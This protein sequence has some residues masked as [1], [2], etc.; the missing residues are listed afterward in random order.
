MSV[1]KQN[2]EFAWPPSDAPA[3]LQFNPVAPQLGTDTA[4]C[5]IATQFSIFFDGTRNHAEE[6][7]PS[8]S[9]SN[10]ARLFETCLAED[11]GGQFRLYIP[12]VGTPFPPIGEPVPH[13]LGARD[14]AYGDR[15]LRYAYLYIANRIAELRGYPL[16]VEET[17]QALA[18][19]IEDET[20]VAVWTGKLSEIF[21]KP[22]PAAPQIVSITLDLFGFSR[23]ATAA[24]AFLNQLLEWTGTWASHMPPNLFGAPLRVRFMG[25]F[26]TVASVHIAD[27]MPLP[28]DGHLKWAEPR[29]MVIPA[30]VEQC[31]HMVAAH[32]ARNS[33]PL[34]TI[35]ASQQDAPRRLEIIYP[36]MHSDVGGGYGPRS[37]GKGTLASAQVRGSEAGMLSQIPLND[38]YDRA[39]AAGV[40]LMDR[41]KLVRHRTA[42]KFTVSPEL[43][44][45]FD[46]YQRTLHAFSSGAPLLTQIHQHYLHYLGWRKH[47]L[48]RG[49]FIAMPFM[50]RCRNGEPQDFVNLDQANVELQTYIVPFM[51]SSDRAVIQAGK[52]LVVHDYLL[53]QHDCMKLYDRYW[54]AL[55]APGEPLRAL[56]E[57]YAHDSRAAFVLTDPQCERDYQ[58]MHADL[59][60]LDA[61]YRES[62]RL[63]EAERVHK[64]QQYE[65]ALDSHDNE[66]FVPGGW[67]Q[68]KQPRPKPPLIRPLPE[69][70]LNEA[71]R[72]ALETYR[73]GRKPIFSDARP[74][75]S[76]DGKE[77][78]LDVIAKFSRRE[79]RWSYL[80]RRQVFRAVTGT[81]D[82]PRGEVRD[83]SKMSRLAFADGLS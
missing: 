61:Q 52:T 36:G 24:R 31:V 2:I 77:D 46:S 82:N 45:A 59:E 60:R 27:S 68:T 17:D 23:G 14:G 80:R 38:M 81:T 7:E 6:D 57:G 56:L 70:P 1:S 63:H 55:P 25:L 32:E 65:K 47:V 43:Q 50:Q 3:T 22:K 21:A 19:A 72:K 42:S 11:Q 83:N 30:F 78:A 48:Q 5:Q 66:V 54:A 28:G 58:T 73:S 76:M 44:R 20:Q 41:S 40:P 26:D 8:G 62:L 79:V 13:P 34:T 37:Q 33:F 75:S 74:G 53:R 10:I 69:D 9:Q 12:G 67:M 18:R 39:C 16:I 51:R 71:D 4:P 49:T 35:S 64:V 29:L 15:R